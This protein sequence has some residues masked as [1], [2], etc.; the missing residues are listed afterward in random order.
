MWGCSRIWEILDS[1]R[2]A[3]FTIRVEDNSFRRERD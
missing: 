1:R 3:S 2:I